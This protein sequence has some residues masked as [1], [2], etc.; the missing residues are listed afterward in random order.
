M[1]VLSRRTGQS[2]W[3]GDDVRITILS[4]D[5]GRIKVGI[6]APAHID[7]QRGELRSDQSSPLSREHA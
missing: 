5:R 3:I 7:I 2:F 1:L 6:E 4:I